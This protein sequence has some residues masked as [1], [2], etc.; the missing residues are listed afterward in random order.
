MSS[1]LE[2]LATVFPD[3]LIHENPSGGGT[4]IKHHVIVQRLL[5]VLGGFDFELVEVLRGHVDAIPADPQGKSARAKR[6]SPALENAVVGAICRL[7]CV[8]DGRRTVIEEVGEVEL[9]HNWKHD[10]ARMKDAMSDAVKRCAARIGC[11]LHLW[12]QQE[13]HLDTWLAKRP[14]ENG[15]VSDAASPRASDGEV[16][17]APA[18]GSLPETAEA[19]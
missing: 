16:E 12:S 6:G 10:G 1:Q 19:K 18:A 8:I 5:Y 7:T 13:Y 9:P 17:P 4:Y 2:Q 11:G 3:T 15:E 14:D